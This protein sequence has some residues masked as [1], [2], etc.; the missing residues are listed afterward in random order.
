MPRG[1][2]NRLQEL[3]T[4]QVRRL[5]FRIFYQDPGTPAHYYEGSGPGC[6]VPGLGRLGPC[7]REEIDRHS[8]Q[9]WYC[10]VVCYEPVNPHAIR[11]GW[12]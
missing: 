11:L 4:R 2:E 1:I 6:I 9:G 5:G 10:I 8:A 3:E 12:G 7:T